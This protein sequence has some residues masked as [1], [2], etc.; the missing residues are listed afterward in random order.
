MKR[1]WKGLKQFGRQALRTH[2]ARTAD[3]ARRRHGPF[4]RPEALEAL[5]SDR[6]C[7]RYPTEVVFTDALAP[8]LFADTEALHAPGG[9]P[10]FRLSVHSAFSGRLDALPALIGYHIPSINY[11]KM[12]STED[13]EC[14]G[15]TLVGWSQETYYQKLCHWADEVG[16]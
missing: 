15:A 6:E 4:D 12:V 16:C 2:L 1:N 11:G 5:L 3:I 8:G 7:V 9:Q 14:F 13:A 10:S